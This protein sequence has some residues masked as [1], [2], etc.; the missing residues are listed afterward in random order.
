MA[1]SRLIIFRHADPKPDANEALGRLALEIQHEL[2]PP[3]VGLTSTAE[4]A[5]MSA[6]AVGDR[7]NLDFIK[8]PVLWSDQEHPEDM[9]GVLSLIRSHPEA[10]TIVLLTHMEIAEYLPRFYVREELGI[11]VAWYDPVRR[12]TIVLVNFDEP[13]PTRQYLR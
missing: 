3:V 6:R 4:R 2:I 13:I 11:R 1:L 8:S 5:L 7:L 9:D 10:K 12:G